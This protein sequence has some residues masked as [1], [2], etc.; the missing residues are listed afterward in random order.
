MKKLLVG[1]EFTQEVTA[2]FRAVGVCAF[3]CD[4][5]AGE[6]N[7]AWHIK[8]DLS[9]LLENSKEWAGLIA[10][11]P[12]THLTQSG[13]R[14][15]E[16]KSKDGRMLAGFTFFEKC[17]NASIPLRAVENPL[18]V[19]SSQRLLN[20][21]LSGRTAYPYSQIFS[22]EQFGDERKKRT[23]LWLRGL[24]VIL[25]EFAARPGRTWL[26]KVPQVAGRGSI[27]SRMSPYIAAA[28]A[29]QWG[30]YFK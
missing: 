19:V 21:Y 12:C 18:G 2:A 14:Y 29:H 30:E 13:G 25:P 28:M 26:E 16:E 24:P 20:R 4:L 6:K 23:C 8:G 10:F 1:C 9:E 22:W 5:A 15:F 27:R 7:E 3:S 11:P 17:L